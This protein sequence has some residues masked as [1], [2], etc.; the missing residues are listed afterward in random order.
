MHVSSLPGSAGIGTFGKPCFDFIDFLKETGQTLWQVLPLGPTGYGDSPYQSFS[1]FALNPLFVDFDDLLERGWADADEVTVPKYIKKSGP[2][3]YGSV[4]WWKTPALASCADFFLANADAGDMGLYKDFCDESKDW[5]DDYATFMSIKS[6]YDKKAEE[7]REAAYK[8]AELA[9][10]SLVKNG[11]DAKTAAEKARTD[12]KIDGRW[13]VYWPKE[14]AKK[15]KAAVAAW[16][17]SHK[18]EIERTKVIQFFAFTQWTAVLAYAR[19]NNVNVVGDIPI[20]VSPDSSDVWANQ[21]CFQF[22]ENG[23][24][25]AVAGV[26]P[27]YFSP[28]G[29]LWGNPLYDWEAVKKSGW[30]WW[31]NRV[32]GMLK[33]CDIIRIDHF[34]GFEAYWAVPFGSKTAESGKWMPGPG[35]ALFDAIKKKLGELPLIAEDLGVITDGVRDLRDGCGLPGMKILQFS[36]DQNEFKNGAMKNAYLPHEY[37]SSSCVVYTGT[38]DND[39]TSGWLDSIDDGTLVTAASYLTGE[40]QT[41]EK[42]KSLRKNGSLLKLMVKAALS[43]SAVYAV[44]PMQDI[45]GVGAEGRMNTPAVASGNWS[46]RMKSSDFDGAKIEKMKKLLADSN[47]LYDRNKTSN[48]N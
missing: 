5:L 34:R 6:F 28:Q 46:W 10:D 37:A 4:V 1:T 31:I 22:D 38:H 8:K 30:K 11:E 9:A 40:V 35:K 27:D 45:L 23:E 36:F 42:A 14:L 32:N 24:Y 19:E 39:T 33:L 15:E 26:P 7:E 48:M 29:Q 17:K 44:I 47:L 3:D 25:S 2:V 20:F 12:V 13:N 21:N 16:K 18:D 43:S 41:L